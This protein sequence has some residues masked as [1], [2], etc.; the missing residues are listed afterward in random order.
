VPARDEILNALR[1][2]APAEVSLPDMRR[3]NALRYP[4]LRERFA[5]SIAEVG[6]RCVLAGGLLEEE[7]ARLPEYA[8]ARMVVSLVPGVAKANLDLAAIGDPHELRDVDFCVLGAELGVAENGAV[9][10]TEHGGKNRAVAF[11]TQHLAIVVR[12]ETLVHNLHEAYEKVAI[13]S[14]GFGLFLSGPSKTADIE[15]SLV[16][17]AHGARSCTVI[18]IG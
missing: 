9:W 8:A 4:D 17:G 1:A 13:P 6:G 15:Q 18:V 10:I 16:I 14:P 3:L 12:A 11:L 5:T 2:A 7:L